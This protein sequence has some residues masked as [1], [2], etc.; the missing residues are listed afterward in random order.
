MRLFI[1]FSLLIVAQLSVCECG[2]RVKRQSGPPIATGEVIN[3]IFQIPIQTLNAVR[4]LFQATRTRVQAIAQATQTAYQQHPNHR[5]N[6]HFSYD[7]GFYNSKAL[8]QPNENKKRRY[9]D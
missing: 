6:P 9:N 3:S 2:I 7:K 8:V 5:P 4:D 1:G